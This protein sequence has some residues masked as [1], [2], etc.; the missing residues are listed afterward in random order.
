VL[1]PSERNQI[2]PSEMI[3]ACCTHS[4]VVNSDVAEPN[5]DKFLHRVEKLLPINLLHNNYD[6]AVQFRN[7]S[8]PNE[9]ESANGGRVAAKTAH[10]SLLITEIT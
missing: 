9:G 1:P 5:F 4:N 10:S 6:I 3:D 2:N 8:V 7:A